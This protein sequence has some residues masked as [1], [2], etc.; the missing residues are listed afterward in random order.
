MTSFPAVGA[1]VM[2]SPGPQ[3][4]WPA[5][6]GKRK[7]S[8]LEPNRQPLIRDCYSSDVRICGISSRLSRKSRHKPNCGYISISILME[9]IHR[10]GL[11]SC[12]HMLCYPFQRVRKLCAIVLDSGRSAICLGQTW[13]GLE[14]IS[15]LG[16]ESR[17]S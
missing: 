7:S 17:S 12:Q 16:G 13:W 1:Q 6:G 2:F 14:N 8:R 4:F 5:P 10:A 9:Q 11:T 3:A 15:H